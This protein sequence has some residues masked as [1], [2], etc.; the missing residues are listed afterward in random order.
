MKL[1]IS[2]KTSCMVKYLQ[3]ETYPLN[4]T[5]AKLTSNNLH[6]RKKKKRM[7]VL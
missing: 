4:T 1:I 5:V 3:I 2:F 6:F 7:Y